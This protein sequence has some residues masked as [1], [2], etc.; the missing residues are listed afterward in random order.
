MELKIIEQ[1]KTKMVIEIKGEDH[2]FCNA[3]KASLQNDADIKYA[4]YTVEHPSISSPVMII[5]GKD[6]KD[7]LMKAAKKLGKDFEKLKESF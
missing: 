7:S 5:E 2:T 4:S 1:S 3:L 6:P